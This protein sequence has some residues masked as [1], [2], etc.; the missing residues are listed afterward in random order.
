MNDDRSRQMTWTSKLVLLAL[1]AMVGWNC[2]DA[3]NFPETPFIEFLGLSKDTIRQGFFQ[4][5]SLIVTFRFEDGDGDIGRDDE[6][7]ENNIFF[8]D[9]RTGTIDYTYGIPAIPQEGAG[10]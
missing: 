8:I 9:E 2:L 5:D 10:N 3:P 7:L 6:E 1:L 4:E